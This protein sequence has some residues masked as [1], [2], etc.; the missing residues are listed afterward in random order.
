MNITVLCLPINKPFDQWKNK[1]S[2]VFVVRQF[3]VL[4]TISYSFFFYNIKVDD[5]FVLFLCVELEHMGNCHN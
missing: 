5:E 3:K 4:V 1:T 2:E